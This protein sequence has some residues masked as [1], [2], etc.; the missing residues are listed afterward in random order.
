MTNRFGRP[1][2]KEL[3]SS[4]LLSL[5]RWDAEATLAPSHGLI[6]SIKLTLKNGATAKECADV[7]GCSIER[8]EQI[9]NMETDF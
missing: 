4:R 6:R 7:L 9:S 2:A 1:T 8:V 3:R 5:A